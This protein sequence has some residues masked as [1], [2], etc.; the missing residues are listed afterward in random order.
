VPAGTGLQ[1][2]IKRG[3][4]RERDPIS[5][6]HVS[7]VAADSAPANAAQFAA[8]AASAATPPLAIT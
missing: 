4:V 8:S 7:A 1:F 2:V 5:V 3:M 6:A